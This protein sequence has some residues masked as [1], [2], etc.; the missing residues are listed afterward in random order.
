MSDICR[1]ITGVSGSPRNLPA[2]RYAAALARGQDATLIPVLAWIPP[3]GDLAERR[4]PSGYLRRVWAQDARERLH[5]ALTVAFGGPPAG[6]ATEPLVIRGAPGRVLVGTAGRPG[7]VL[8]IGTG[9]HGTLGRL[10]GGSVS[11]YCVAR[12]SCPVL[13]VPPAMLE[14]AAGHGL[15]RWAFRHR[16][17][18]TGELTAAS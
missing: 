10:A 14:L 13:A 15:R 12:A 1:V 6:V 17:L 2:L 4:H 7:D 11:R 18:S 9:R 3:G 8:V 16:E 5:D